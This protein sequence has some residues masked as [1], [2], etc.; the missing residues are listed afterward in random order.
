[1]NPEQLQHPNNVLQSHHI[2]SPIPSSV[3]S[4]RPP[5]R[6]SHVDSH[7]GA[8]SLPQDSQQGLLGVLHSLNSS[9]QQ[10][11]SQLSSGLTPGIERLSFDRHPIPRPP[12]VNTTHGPYLPP[13][14]DHF[15]STPSPP[16]ST[17]PRYVPPHRLRQIPPHRPGGPNR[18][19]DYTPREPLPIGTIRFS[20]ASSELETFLL[21]I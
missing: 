13:V 19:A 16:P 14:I 18:Q 15:A 12:P 21:D 7:L 1:M 3:Q 5:S 9:V 10:L 20:G 4:Q 8:A 11:S 17:G 2:L 6:P